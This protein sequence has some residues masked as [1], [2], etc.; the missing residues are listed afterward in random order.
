MPVRPVAPA[1]AVFA[2][3]CLV[4]A[5]AGLTF[6]VRAFSPT[7]TAQALSLLFLVP[8]AVS[9]HRF[10]L[11]IALLTSA[12][13]IVCWDYLFG[14]PYY[15]LVI[16]DPGDVF[17][18]AVFLVVAVVIAGLSA[19]IRSQ[20]ERLATEALTL[21][22]TVDFSRAMQRLATVAALA[23]FTVTY[24]RE[25]FGRDAVVILGTRGSGS[26]IFPPSVEL[27]ETERSASDLLV[28]QGAS[29][30]SS[31]DGGR[32]TFVPLDGHRGRIG[33]IGVARGGQD[34]LSSA[35]ERYFGAIVSQASIALERAR[36]AHDIEAARPVPQ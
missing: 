2:S 25:K 8:V 27:D 34:G 13:S 28:A 23:S 22:D 35:D 33:T 30:A 15:S 5:T 26:R 32:Y 17:A 4:A 14:A 6:L 36:L 3:L 1:V 24:V 11:W 10:G 16:K 31:R 20:R 9:A 18:L 19:R 21:S 29:D 7:A 12:L